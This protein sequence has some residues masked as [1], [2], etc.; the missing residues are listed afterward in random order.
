MAPHAE[1]SASV[2]TDGYPTEIAEPQTQA[3]PVQLAVVPQDDY[4]FT[5]NNQN[6]ETPLELGNDAEY[7]IGEHIMWAPRK[8]R[9]ACIGAG[10]AGIM[11]CYKKEKEFGDDIDLVVYERYPSP[12]G[13]WYANRYP[14]CKCDVPSAGYQY[15]FS[16]SA[17]WPKYYSSA[18]EIWKYYSDFANSH[19]YVEKYMKLSH[20]ITR[21]DWVEDLAKWRLSI[22]ETLPSGDKRQFMDEVDFLI[23]NIGVLN[24]WKWPEI[25]NR[26][27]YKGQITHSANYDT[28]IDC[29]GKR[30]CV[31]GSGASSVQII[32]VVQKQASHLVSFYRTPQWISSGLG[33]EGWTDAA[34]GNFTYTEEQKQK[35]RDD[36][37]HYLEFRK[38]IENKIN[39]SFRAMLKDHPFQK[40]G[41]EMVEKSMAER[42][43]ND[44][45]LTKQLIPDF[46]MGCR[47]L[48]P[49]EGFLEALIAENVTIAR[50]GAASFSEKGVTCEDGT[51]YEFDV[52]IC[53]TGFDVSFRPYFPIVG[54]EG[55][56]LADEWTPTPEAYLAMAA[57]GFPNFF[58]GSLG[59]NCP[60]GH[61]SF[62]TVIEAAQ[63][64]ICKII[65]KLQTENIRSI[66]VK[67][68]VVEEYNQHVHKWLQR[69][70]VVYPFL[71]PNSSLIS[72]P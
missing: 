19:G 54:R 53:A 6:G 59:P 14:G 43:K 51:E 50:S 41:R 31:I 5:F 61:G 10:S 66:D 57:H 16:P 63:N 13:V 32:P 62:V 60:A 20:E 36:P 26:E 9:V 69:T 68:N 28:S 71:L 3:F 2:T 39:G 55:K 70:F 58:I 65:R 1:V 46:A 7:T 27:H 8:I 4:S 30:V 35:F 52:I 18:E 56:N 40:I 15:S 67:K 64:Y 45:V 25:P 44:P 11:F 29:T 12:G 72:L 38:A 34:G 17:E 48:G 42:L 22:T 47:R 33:I 49:G 23:G 24:T 21:A 37:K